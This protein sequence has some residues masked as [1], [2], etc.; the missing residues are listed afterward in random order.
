MYVYGWAG[1]GSAETWK[2]LWFFIRAREDADIIGF[3]C[4]LNGKINDTK[5][6]AC[7]DSGLI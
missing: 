7:L 1:I 3:V 2:G 5:H 6:D 4:W